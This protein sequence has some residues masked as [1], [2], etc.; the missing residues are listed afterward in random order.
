MYSKNK[1]END[2]PSDFSDCFPVAC[3]ANGILTSIR[4]LANEKRQ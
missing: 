3:R 1:T 4:L 2:S